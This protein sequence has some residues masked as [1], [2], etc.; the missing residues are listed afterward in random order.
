MEIVSSE[1]IRLAADSPTIP[2][3]APGAGA[4]PVHPTTRD[5]SGSQSGQRRQKKRKEKE[6]AEDA[7]RKDDP[8]GKKVDEP[9][10]D[11]PKPDEPKPDDP[12]P[13]S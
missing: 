9:N 13:K 7:P 10:P 12:K 8:K 2:R 4:V 11:E 6:E 5:R 3:I 1:P